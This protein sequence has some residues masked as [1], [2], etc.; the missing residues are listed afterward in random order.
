M[1]SAAPVAWMITPKRMK[2]ITLLIMIDKSKPMAP[3]VS[4]Q[5]FIAISS[6]V[7]GDVG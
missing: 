2:M 5:K 3:V 6:Q 1:A 4:N 7:L